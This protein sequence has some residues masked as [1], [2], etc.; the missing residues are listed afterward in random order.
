MTFPK[1]TWNNGGAP[2]ISAEQLNRI[3]QGIADAHDQIEKDSTQQATLTHGQNV[4]TTDQSTPLDVKVK[5][6]TLV[7]HPGREGGFHKQGLWSTALTID[8]ANYKFGTS[9][10]KIDNSAGTVA[11]S[12]TNGQD[13]FLAGKYVLVG[14]W[15]KSASGTPSIKLN[16]LERDSAN[17][18]ISSDSV[19][20]TIN[21]SWNFYYFKVDLTAKSGHHWEIGLNV[22]TYGT[23]NDIVNF[24][25]L[26]VYEIDSTTNNAI[27]VDPE[28]TGDK[29]ADK[30]PYVDSV[31]HVQNPVVK[32]YGKNLIK[33]FTGWDSLH[34]NATVVSPYE[35]ELNATGG[36]QQ[37]FVEI[38][39][40]SS[41]S[42][43]LKANIT[44]S[45]DAG[46]MQIEKYD[47]T[48][49]KVGTTV[50]LS[51]NEISETF[52]TD[53]N[54]TKIKVS[55]MSNISG[56]FTFTNPQLEL[57]STATEFEPQNPSYLYG[58]T[59]LAS[60]I[61]GTVEDEMYQRDGQWYRLNRWKKDVVLD[62][63]LGWEFS[64]DKVDYKQARLHVNNLPDIKMYPVLTSG[65]PLS[66]YDG[67]IIKEQS[68]DNGADGF[69][70]ND[71]S[72][73]LNITIADTDS[74]WPQYEKPRTDDIKGYFYGW[75]VNG[76][77]LGT[78]VVD[79]AT[80]SIASGG[81]Y[82]FVNTGNHR[83]IVVEKSSDNVTFTSAT[84]GTDYTLSWDET[85]MTLTNAT[86]GALYFRVDYNY[87]YVANSWASLVDGTA[88]S[89]NTLAYVSTNIAPNFTPYSLTY[90]LATAQEEPVTVE[91]ALNLIDGGNQVSVEEGLINREEATPSLN[92][93]TGYYVINHNTY[94]ESVIDNRTNKI[95]KVYKNGA[96]DKSWEI[97]S[98][99][100]S[101]NGGGWARILESN[102]DTTAEYTVTYTALDKHLLTVNTTEVIATYS[103]NLHSVVSGVVKRQS[104]IETHNTIQDWQFENVA[105]KGAGERIEKGI[106][107]VDTVSSVSG[108]VTITFEKA[109]SETPIISA[110][111]EYSVYNAYC[112]SV[113]T[114]GFTL[115]IRHIDNVSMSS[116]GPV[117]WTAIGK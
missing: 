47:N 30:Y 98:D 70:I 59:K 85:T 20:K 116:G 14:A 22:N 95:I 54:V 19:D 45:V 36:Y 68:V 91:G 26:V 41:T 96:E 29:L 67:K 99:S 16:L 49:T 97:G 107:R 81:T 25:G 17:A 80:G 65:Y 86:A 88:P 38:P 102:F 44:E 79:E 23:A 106:I 15:V 71:T 60:N 48:N 69:N 108:T 63:S 32:S 8:T 31:K 10:G 87:G 105:V 110:I 72:S 101:Y 12:S 37:S 33:P 84:E 3:E 51:D 73:L 92:G 66:K 115:G 46:Y 82:N 57:G 103:T 11:K 64:L 24:D 78:D 94:P 4:I 2:G 58:V 13:M 111:T 53:S 5:G 62:G 9:S 74:G 42:Y 104:D 75:K 109:F 100:A 50:Y 18:T 89:T 6:K 52:T 61:D 43:T 112:G 56:T 7:N 34:A 55:A 28:Y 77:T 40:S 39:V 93:T 21:S 35:L 76:H 90:Q 83:N 113:T 117:H 27:D 114:T 1:T